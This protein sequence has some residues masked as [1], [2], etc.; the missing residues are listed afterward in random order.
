MIKVTSKTLPKVKDAGRQL[1][2]VEASEVAAA[3][4]AEPVV[5]AVTLPQ[6]PLGLFALRQRACGAP[7][8]D[9]R[10]S[11]ARAAAAPEDSAQRRGLGH[12][13]EAR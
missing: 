2:R 12:S 3:L 8:F 4:G 7:S 13:G 5:G 9:R 11:R 1:R 6:G 10:T